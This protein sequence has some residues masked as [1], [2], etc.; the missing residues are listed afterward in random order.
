MNHF[1]KKR[2]ISLVGLGE[3]LLLSVVGSIGVG[4]LAG[5]SSAI[6]LILLDKATAWREANIWIIAFLPIAGFL[7]G[8]IYHYWGKELSKGNNYIL[9]EFYTPQKTIPLRMTFLVLIGTLLTHLFGGSAGREG[10][11]VQMGSSLAD[12]IS[13]WFRLSSRYRRYLLIMG[14]SAG[15]GSVF[16]TPLAGAFFALEVFKIGKIRYDAILPSFL[17]AFVGD[18]VCDAWNVTHTHYAIENIP[19]LTIF[20]LCW[21]LV[22]GICFGG[23]ARLFAE[24]S[25]FWS[26]I[27]KYILY[28]PFRPLL[29]GFLIAIF[30]FVSGSTR[31]VGLGIPVIMSSFSEESYFYDFFA[32]TLLTTF[33]LGAGFKGGE[34]TP[35]F[36]VGATLGNTLS[37]W[38]P[39]GRSLL[40]GMGF[41][42]VFAG[43]THTPIACL[44]MAIEIFGAQG[45]TYFGIACVTAYVFSGHSGIYTSQMIGVAK[46]RYSVKWVGKKIGEI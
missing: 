35:L 10:T 16:G 36:F 42:A 22:A 27:F 28:P 31:Y 4:I 17:A 43:A 1:F 46:H 15:F 45:S 41:A 39:L 18:Y 24:L 40:A 32:K 12:Q 6:F 26:R 38:I 30:V 19:K 5:T 44:L 8:W 21:A 34:V 9:E 37:T 20:N 3:H 25:H 33:T 13:K 2:V 14:V 23:V 29:G 11:A 7:I